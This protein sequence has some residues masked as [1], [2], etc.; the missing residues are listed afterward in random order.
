MNS[1]VDFYDAHSQRAA[2]DVY[3][4]V[5]EETYG[6]DFGQT[7]WITASECD[8]F[9]R[10]LDLKAGQRVLEIASGSGGTAVRLA[11]RLGVRVSGIDA[12]PAA[13]FAATQRAREHSV[14]DRVTFDLG[15]A[16]EALAFPDGSFEAIF[17]ND[18]IN[19]LP[20]R[21]AVLA[22]W[23]RVLRPGGRFLYTDPVVVTG[24]LSNA[25]VAARS[26]IGFFLFAPRGFNETCIGAAGFRLLLA[27]D[28]TAG[29]SLTSKRW[30]DARARRRAELCAR[31]GPAR[32]EE[33]QRFLAVVHDLASGRRLSRF[34]FLGEKPSQ[35]R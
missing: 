15:D 29:V 19:H 28:A 21:P 6:E 13:V 18:S 25:E 4:A 33:L 27:E 3:R 1:S 11:R 2:E 14:E 35:G 20:D 32:F 12:N 31:E 7:S 26:A 9:C 23:R 22:E 34:A 30:R 16:S 8:E 17:C 5:R 24:G 10:W